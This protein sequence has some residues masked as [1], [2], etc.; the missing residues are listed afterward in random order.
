VQE[1]ISAEYF[2]RGWHNM[3]VFNN[4]LWII[5]GETVDQ[6]GDTVLLDDCW[7]SSDGISWQAGSSIVSFSPRKM[8]V[9]TVINGKLRLWGGYGQNL[10]GQTGALNDAWSTTNGETWLLESSTSPFGSRC[11]AGYVFYN[12]RIW[13][14]GGASSPVAFGATYYNDIWAS[15]DGLNWV[16]IAKNAEGTAQHFSPRGFHQ[17]S[18]L[19]GR[20]YLSGGEQET[21]LLN[22]VWL[23]Q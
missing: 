3:V 11:G 19:N 10:N 13:I 23:S 17:L 4:K 21:G 15:N 5:A 14:T 20:I 16:E 6:N 2:S 9:A 8:A 22:E 1:N 12:D 7:S 18:A